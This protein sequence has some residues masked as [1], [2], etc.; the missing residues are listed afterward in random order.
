METFPNTVRPAN[1]DKPVIVVPPV[2]FP[3]VTGPV[4]P[5]P[6][7]VVAAVVVLMFVVPCRED[8]PVTVRFPED[9]VKLPEVKVTFPD[10]TNT[11][12]DV[13]VNPVPAVIVVPAVTDPGNET[14]PGKLKVRLCV[15]ASP[16][17]TI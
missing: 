11:L 7:A 3:I 8:V 6:I 10:E 1:V 17:T 12:P 13:T 9:S 5:V 14:L 15:A 16:V 4:P 2:V